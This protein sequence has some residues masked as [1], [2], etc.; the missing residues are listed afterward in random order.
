MGTVIPVASGKGGVGKTVVAANLGLALSALGKTVVLVDLDLGG[1]NLHTV[2]GVRN[3]HAGLGS[4]IWRTETKLDTLVVATGYPRLYLIPGDS[5]LPG[6][7]NPDYSIK[8]RIMRDLGTLP[9]DFV[10]LDLGAGSSYTVVDFWLMAPDGFLVVVPEI[11][12]ILNAYSFLKTAA[13]RLFLRSFPRGDEA[14]AQALRHAA[15]SREGKAQRLLD[16]AV[17]L[18]GQAGERGAQALEALRSLKPRVI[19]NL[20]EGTAGE[21]ELAGRLGGIAKAHLGIDPEYVATLP[22]DPA[23]SSSIARPEPVLAMS[24]QAPFSLAL[25]G[26]ARQLAGG[27]GQK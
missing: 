16:F 26:L 17:D 4:L 10:I 13:F 5:L 27:S 18:A 19:V 14:R 1:A 15:G 6:T 24:P 3:R 22:R 12:S 8:R 21:P 25:A 7:A 23:V 9:A 2:L 11:P 20:A